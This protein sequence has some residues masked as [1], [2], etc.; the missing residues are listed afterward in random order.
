[1]QSGKL[2][3]SFVIA[4]AGHHDA[5]GVHAELPLDIPP[6]SSDIQDKFTHT[7]QRITMIGARSEHE[8][9]V[10]DTSCES[11]LYNAFVVIFEAIEALR[12][13]THVSSLKM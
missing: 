2:L 12:Q 1:M 9:H 4:I 11:W 6:L 5:C 10:S 7:F 8:W 13:V 3:C